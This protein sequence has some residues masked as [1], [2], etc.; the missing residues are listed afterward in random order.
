MSD[1]IAARQKALDFLSRREYSF[2]G[3]KQRLIQAG[4]CPDVSSDVLAD[5]SAE[6]LLDERRFLDDTLLKAKRSGYG[7]L[8]LHMRWEEAGIAPALQAQYDEATD[9]LDYALGLAQAWHHSGLSILKIG[10]RLQ[11]KGHAAPVISDVLHALDPNDTVY[12]MGYD[13]V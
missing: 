3:L 1:A 13:G 7:P 6:G 9:W 8:W 5:L 11:Q 4:F 2:L 12:D 10:R